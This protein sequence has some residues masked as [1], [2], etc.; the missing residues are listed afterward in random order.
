MSVSEKKRVWV[1]I[2][3][4][5]G[6][7]ITIFKWGIVH[8]TLFPESKINILHLKIIKT[9]SR[10]VSYSY[11]GI[12]K[13]KL[14]KEIIFSGKSGL[15]VW[16]KRKKKCFTFT[17]MELNIQFICTLY[18]QSSGWDFQRKEKRSEYKIF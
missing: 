16:L 2:Y 14:K 8:Y 3:I 17:L 11:Y 6:L 4:S 12:Q 13:K 7:Q 5:Q 15:C 10:S 1:V 18:K 9:Q